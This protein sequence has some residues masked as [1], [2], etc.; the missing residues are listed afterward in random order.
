MFC[1]L[2]EVLMQDLYAKLSCCHLVSHSI[3]EQVWAIRS[4]NMQ[5]LIGD[6]QLSGSP[7]SSSVVIATFEYRS[8]VAP[9]PH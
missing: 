9:L 2:E 4:L 3:H 7:Q 1:K 6:L 8:G 5:V